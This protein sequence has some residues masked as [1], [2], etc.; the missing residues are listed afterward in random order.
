VQSLSAT[1]TDITVTGNDTD[2]TGNHDI[3]GTLDTVD[4]GLTATVQVVELGLGDTVVNVD[5]GD[6]ELA[7]L[8]HAVQV[9]D[10]GGGLLGD[11]EAVLEHLGVL[12]VDKGGQ[13][14]TVVKDEVELLVILEGKEL[15]L[16]TPLVL[17]LG[18]T[19]PG[20]D[21]DTGGS[22][23]SGGVVLSGEDVAGSPGDL[24]TESSE[25]L[26]EDSGLDG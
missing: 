4:E 14:T 25:G 17:L 1:L 5:G 12:G 23:G 24:S 15:L 22:N 20:E 8:E 21:R 6:L 13:V 2:L 16:E 3:G 18:L 9:V 11:T 19:L 26:D 7:L 10:T